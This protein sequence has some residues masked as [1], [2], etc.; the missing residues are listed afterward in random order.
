MQNTLSF[1]QEILQSVQAAYEKR[2]EYYKK[3]AQAAYGG[4]ALDFPITKYPPLDRLVIL[5]CCV[6]VIREK[7][8]D[9]G[10]PEHILLETLSDIPLRARLYHEKTGRTGLSKDD[11]IWFRHL[12]FTEIFQFGSLQ[13]QPFSMLYLDEEGCGEAYMRYDGWCK[14]ALPQGA[15]VVNIHIP[16]GANLSPELVEES[17][18]LAVDFFGKYLPEHP[19]KYFV[20]YSWLLYPGLRELLPENSRICSFAD[21]F[22]IIGYAQDPMESIHRIYGRRWKRRADFP[23]DTA[24]QRNALGN[25]S[26]LGEGCGILSM[27]NGKGF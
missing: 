13:F 4:K 2:P 14:D 6:P 24:L 9:L 1:P 15:P 8:V 10:T 16:A 12:Y 25:F 18:S 17:L 7:Y 3:A 27:N 5:C 26:R 20:C 22:R 11:A 23:Q 19:A 21:R